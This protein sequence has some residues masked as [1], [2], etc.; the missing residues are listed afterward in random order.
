[1]EDDVPARSRV[2]ADRAVWVRK[3]GRGTRT[4]LQSAGGDNEGG[5]ADA[6]RL[7]ETR[8]RARRV[9]DDLYVVCA[10]LRGLRGLRGLRA[11]YARER[12]RERER[13]EGEQPVHFKPLIATQRA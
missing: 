13:D 6:H 12:E 9:V 7:S 1:M 2:L 10:R 4:R 3:P 11:R 5:G 8:L